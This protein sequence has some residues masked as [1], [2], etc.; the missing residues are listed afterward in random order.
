MLSILVVLSNTLHVTLVCQG[1]SPQ[2]MQWQGKNPIIDDWGD[3]VP[4]TGHIDQR[5]YIDQGRMDTGLIGTHTPN[6]GNGKTF[7]AGSGAG[8]A[9]TLALEQ[10]PA[11]ALPSYGV[12]IDGSCA[13]SGGGDADPD[14]LVAHSNKRVLQAMPS[15]E[16]LAHVERKHKI[17]QLQRDTMDLHLQRAAITKARKVAAHAAWE[18]QQSHRQATA[19]RAKEKT[20]QLQASCGRLGWS[21]AR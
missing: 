5:H 13:D 10:G 11:L 12:G 14:Q 21:V 8:P 17:A 2:A 6:L 9:F 15:E 18:A 3:L 7:R 20:K 4:E 19:E 16:E 1:P